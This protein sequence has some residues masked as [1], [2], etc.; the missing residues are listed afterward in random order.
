MVAVRYGSEAVLQ[1]CE[2]KHKTSRAS[3]L[4]ESV[5]GMP[6]RL[7][8]VDFLAQRLGGA[9]KVRA[10][11]RA[12]ELVR[13][14]PEPASLAIHAE[15]DDRDHPKIPLTRPSVVSVGHARRLSESFL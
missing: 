8:I 11:T 1:I 4:F 9:R 13:F 2:K 12:Q 5:R 3:S 15:H 10:R 6:S 14:S 7:R